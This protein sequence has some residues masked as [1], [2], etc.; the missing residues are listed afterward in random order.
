MLRAQSQSLLQQ[1][2]CCLTQRSPTLP[3][4][5]SLHRASFA[6]RRGQACFSGRKSQGTSL[7]MQSCVRQRSRMSRGRTMATKAMVN[8]DFASPSMLLGAVLIGGGVILLQ[9]RNVEN[10]VSRDADIVVAACISIVGS[11]L[12][13]Q[14]WRLDPLL[15]L[16]QQ[17][18]PYQQQ[19]QQQQPQRRAAGAG[20]FQNAMR[21][22]QRSGSPPPTGNGGG[23]QP[24]GGGYAGAW[25]DLEMLEGAPPAPGAVPAAYALPPGTAQQAL[26]AVL[27]GMTRFMGGPASAW[28]GG[29]GGATVAPDESLASSTY[30]YYPQDQ[31]PSVSQTLT[32]LP[33]SPQLDDPSAFPSSAPY[34]PSF[35]AE[36]SGSSYF[37]ASPSYEPPFT[38]SSTAS[39]RGDPPAATLTPFDGYGAYDAPPDAFEGATSSVYNG[40]YGGTEPPTSSAATS[41][42][43]APTGA[44]LDGSGPQG[45]TFPSYLYPPGYGADAEAAE[46]GYTAPWLDGEDLEEGIGRLD[47][48]PLVPGVAENKDHL[49]STSAAEVGSSTSG[50]SVSTS[51]Q[52]IGPAEQQQQEQ[53]RAA[54]GMQFEGRMS[55]SAAV[56]E[57]E[58]NARISSQ[59]SNVEVGRPSHANSES[60]ENGTSKAG[61]SSGLASF[62]SGRKTQ[63]P[64][65]LRRA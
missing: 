62:D 37:D 6:E 64:E 1:R 7:L 38:G 5:A 56:P 33:S 8:V 23:A 29:Q 59:M 42:V 28:L 32:A 17:Y 13:F 46:D 58:E 36:I 49:P 43:N 21:R 34:T 22:R 3:V 57:A 27:H 45:S 50:S 54:Q 30:S 48:P 47:K 18:P 12:I 4:A 51:G 25:E 2:R 9:M 20:Y 24:Y 35:P 44:E 26:H 15:L 60:G 14:G 61:D 31:D 53:P 40:L 41:A 52:S 63:Q 65:D 11:T 19:Q 55:A 39:Y 10:R 16:C